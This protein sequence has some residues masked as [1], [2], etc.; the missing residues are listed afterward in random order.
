MRGGGPHK[1]V[2]I[3][4]EG[5]RSGAEGKAQ[6]TYWYKSSKPDDII[7]FPHNGAILIK[8]VAAAEGEKAWIG[9]IL[10]TT[11]SW[12]CLY[13]LGDN[14]AASLDSRYWA[15]PFVRI[16]DGIARYRR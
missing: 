2:R 11:V 14:M 6:V 13:V 10:F 8:R 16:D 4:G 15:A 1:A 7:V 12:G 5:R 9:G 3:Y